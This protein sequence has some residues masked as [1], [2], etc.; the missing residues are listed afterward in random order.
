MAYN[1]AGL[2]CALN[3]CVEGCVRLS[4]RGCA[5]V[6]QQQLLCLAR[7]LLRRPRIV[8]LDECTANVDAVTARLMQDLIASQLSHATILQVTLLPALC[9]Y[10]S[11]YVDTK[12]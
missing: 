9:H 11:Y 4:V 5:G 8:C 2:R 10:L 1:L 3:S 7:V 6:G 12:L